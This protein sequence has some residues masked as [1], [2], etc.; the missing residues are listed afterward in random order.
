MIIEEFIEPVSSNRWASGD[1][2]ITLTSIDLPIQRFEAPR[3]APRSIVL[4]NYPAI[5]RASGRR[6]V[7]VFSA[8]GPFPVTVRDTTPTILKVVP[9]NMAAR[10]CVEQDSAGAWRL[11]DYALL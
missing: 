7:L 6:F 3:T 11:A 4:A 10:V 9:S 2:D 8:G 5:A 1:I